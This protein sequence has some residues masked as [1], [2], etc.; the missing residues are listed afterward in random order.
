VETLIK[1]I[2]SRNMIALGNMLLYARKSNTGQNTKVRLWDEPYLLINIFFAGVIL[3]IFAYSGFFSPEK[4]NYPVVCLHEKVTGQPCIS[5]GLSHS[6]SL[7]VRGKVG[8]A[9]HWNRYGM[10]IFLFF[11]AQLVLRVAFSIFYLKYAETRKQLIIIDCIG[12]GIIFFVA[13][14]PFIASIISGILF[15]V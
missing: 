3:L 12:S 2:V 15:G 11:V 8:E 4:D 14:W 13:F 6:F 7:I 10:R 9:Y 5:C 1:A